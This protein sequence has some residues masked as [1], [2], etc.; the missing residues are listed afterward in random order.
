MIQLD[1]YGYPPRPD[2]RGTLRKKGIHASKL[3]LSK[4][5]YLCMCIVGALLWLG[6]IG[7]NLAP[8]SPR[9]VQPHH[10]LVIRLDLI[11]DLVLSMTVARAL[12]RAYPGAEIDLL[13]LPSS[14]Q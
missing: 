6:R 7:K 4:C 5:L 13:A 10:I 9:T 8:L 2:A 11:G 12:K 14:V 1:D 3:T